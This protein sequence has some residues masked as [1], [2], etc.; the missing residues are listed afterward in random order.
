[1]S[2]SSTSRLSFQI[3]PT[4]MVSFYNI[5]FSKTLLDLKLFL[6]SLATQICFQNGVSQ[7]QV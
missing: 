1:M 5:Y 7:G 2:F 3:S 4:Q 6:F